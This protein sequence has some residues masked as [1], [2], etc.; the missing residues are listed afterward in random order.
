M[1]MVV[2][3]PDE[4]VARVRT[5]VADGSY[6]DPEQFLELAL[7]NQLEMEESEQSSLPSFGEAV[8]SGR[9]E[10][11][12]LLTAAHESES[13]V[14]EANDPDTSDH[15]ED[16]SWR[17]FEVQTVA[18]PDESR[19]DDGPLWGQYNR[20]FP[21]KLVVRR[22]A[23]LLADGENGRV[24]YKRF[25][26]ETA[27]TAREY[28]L[29]LEEIDD[30]Q[31]R[32]RGEKLASAL[33]TSDKKDRSLERFKTHFVGQLE[34]SGELTGAAPD[35]RFV[36]IHPDEKTFGLTDAGLEFASIRNP[37][38]DEG[39]EAEQSLSAEEREFYVKHV[40]S[41]VTDE[42]EAM[43]FLADAVMEGVNRPTSLTEKIAELNDNWS[44][45]QAKTVRSGL[46][47]RMVELGL[48]S[49]HR[50]GAR[51]TGYDVTDEGRH[52]LLPQIE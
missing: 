4:L 21:V 50:V 22:L 13:E 24:S 23:T 18:P 34:T 12:N 16:L 38:L 30:L 5:A 3:I 36:D 43:Q 20:L 27:T 15:L 32:G 2:D 45:S 26:E 29:R 1:K 37:L 11:Q 40:R 6:D 7:R 19:L 8:G 17:S 33:P 14:K 31:D 9:P 25:R 10:Q 39:L 28:G 44:E 51:G 47:S 48:L 35:L 46:V 52:L 42:Y 41:A 49:R